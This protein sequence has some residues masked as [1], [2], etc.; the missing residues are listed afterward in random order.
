MHPLNPLIILALAQFTS[1]APTSDFSD[2]TGYLTP[3]LNSTSTA[4]DSS[5]TPHGHCQPSNTTAFVKLSA[6]YVSLRLD[7]HY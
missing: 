6:I 2:L 3:P 1:P 4:I 7:P 5:T